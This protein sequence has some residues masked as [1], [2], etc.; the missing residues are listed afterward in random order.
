MLMD[1][2]SER[3]FQFKSMFSPGTFRVCLKKYLNI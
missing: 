2:E 1:F 3:S